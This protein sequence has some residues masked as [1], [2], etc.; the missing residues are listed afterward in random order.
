MIARPRAPV[1]GKFSLTYP[2]M[3]GQKKQTPRANT[4]AVAES[5]RRG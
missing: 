3:V 5:F 2:S 1:F 4:V